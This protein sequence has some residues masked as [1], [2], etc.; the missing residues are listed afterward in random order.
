MFVTGASDILPLPPVV[1]RNDANKNQASKQAT[2]SQPPVREESVMTYFSPV[3]RIDPETQ[4]T[5]IIFREEDGE[6][7]KQYPS[8]EELE[9]YRQERFDSASSGPA[10]TRSVEGSTDD[11]GTTS[12]APAAPTVNVGSV[13]TPD[14][15]KPEV[16]KPTTG[17]SGSGFSA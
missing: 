3:V 11:G 15:P 5:I 17:E 7:T 8:E 14:A 10:E 9:A 6:V 2:E 13:E 4:Q 1:G 16:T 12:E